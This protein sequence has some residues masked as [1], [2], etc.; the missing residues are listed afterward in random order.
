LKCLNSP[1]H[2]TAL[3]RAIPTHQHSTQQ[4][5]LMRSAGEEANSLNNQSCH[6]GSRVSHQQR[7]LQTVTPVASLDDWAGL[8]PTRQRKPPKNGTHYQWYCCY[9]TC[10]ILVLRLGTVLQV[11]I[12]VL[13]LL[14]ALV[15]RDAG[16]T[17]T[18]VMCLRSESLTSGSLYVVRH[19][20]SRATRRENAMG[21]VL[22]I[23]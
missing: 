20:R 7:A 18:T 6:L 8:Q 5:C 19:T 2:S 1:V 10:M 16:H 23:K 14:L 9:I 21:R 22:C 12:H 3:E 4:C 15:L 17:T 13:F 11:N